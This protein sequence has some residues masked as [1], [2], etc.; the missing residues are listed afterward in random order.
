M[1]NDRQRHRIVVLVGV[2]VLLALLGIASVTIL[3]PLCSPGR[4]S[5]GDNF[6][7]KRFIWI[8]PGTVCT[9]TGK[10]SESTRFTL[11]PVAPLIITIAVLAGIVRM[12][13]VT[14]HRTTRPAD[15]SVVEYEQQ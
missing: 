5:S 8:P 9:T 14:R 2:C 1:R 4:S 11:N 7:D 15:S 13:G 6:V 3:S 12:S 10:S